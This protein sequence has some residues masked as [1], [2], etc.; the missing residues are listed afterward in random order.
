MPSTTAA[1]TASRS[2]SGKAISAFLPPSFSS[3]TG[4]SVSEAAFITARP[5][6]T[7]PMSATLATFGMARQHL[8]DLLAAGDEVPHARRQDAVD[9]LGEPQRGQRRLLRRLNHDGV[10]GGERR[11][12]LA[13]DEHEG[14]VERDDA[15]DHAEGLAHGEVHRVRSD[16]D[17][18]PF[19][20]GDEAGIEIELRGA[21][22]RVAPHFGVG[23]A[24]VG[25]VDH[26]E[27]VAVLAQHVGDRAQH[28]CAFERRHAPPLPERGLGGGDGGFRVRHRAVDHLAQR[29]A[30][31]GIDGVDVKRSAFGCCHLP[32]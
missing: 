17:R 18:G 2:A 29:L 23:V 11:R 7:L 26:G 14:M 4:L 27:V 25:G 9:Q 15:S 28:L 8:A 3:S 30:G 13:R 5:V 22:L 12:R 19:H 32:A 10:S 21:H 20:L 16:R 1:E 31:A 6:G 24:A